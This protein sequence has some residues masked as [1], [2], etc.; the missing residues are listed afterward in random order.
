MTDI[1][2]LIHL[3]ADDPD[4]PVPPVVP[5]EY[6]LLAVDEIELLRETILGKTYTFNDDLKWVPEDIIHVQSERIKQLEDECQK[7]A[8]YLMHELVF[9][10]EKLIEE[11]DVSLEPYLGG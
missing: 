7:L 11:V 9:V 1:V 2:K 4:S 3:W 10:H 6:A 8:N 5:T